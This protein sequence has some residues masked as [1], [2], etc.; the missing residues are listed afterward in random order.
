M[1]SAAAMLAQTVGVRPYELDW[2]G[3][4][5]DDHPAIVD[6]ETP[7]EWRV[8]CKDAVATFERTREQQIWGSFVGKLTYH[9]TGESPV[10]RILLQTPV[11]I[12]TTFD[13]VTCWIYGNNWG[14]APDPNTPQVSVDALF[15]DAS[16]A[17]FSLP[18]ANVSW[19]EWFLCH[20]RLNAYGI[21]RMANG[22]VFKGFVI[23]NGRNKQDRTLFFDSLAVFT[24]VFKP[25][26]FEPRPKRGIVMFPG[27]TTGTNTGPG[28][29]PFPTRDQTILP[30]NL[31][32]TAKSFLTVEKG[33]YIFHYAG[34]DGQL[35]YRLTPKTG[36]LGDVTARWTGRGGVIRPCVGGGVLLQGDGAPIAPDRAENLGVT[37]K[38]DTVV[39]RWRVHAGAITSEVSY[40][41][42]LWGKSLVVDVIAPGGNVGEVRYGRALGLS[43]PRLVTLPYYLYNNTRPAVAVSGP[44][45]APLFLSAHTD[46]CLSNAS[47]L[48]AINDIS[49]SGV[50][51]N[52]GTQYIAKTDGKRND[53]YERLFI[54]LT[55]NFEETLPNIPNPVS[56]YKKVTGTHLWYAHGA[57]NRQDDMN[58]W[59]ECKR[60][61]MEQV[62]ITDHETMWRDG[63]ESF[64]FRTKA[65][66]KKGGDE[67]ERA[68]SRYMQDVLGFV[69][70]PYNNYTDFAP[71]NEFWSADMI[72]RTPDNQLQ[73]AWMRCYAPKPARAVEYCARLAPQIQSKYGFSTAYCDVHTAVAP[74]ERVDYD[75]RVPGAGTFGAVFYSYGEIMMLQKAAWKGPVYSEGGH[76][77]MYCGLTDG[78]YGQDQNY[79][80]ATKPWLVD[81]DLRKMHDLG[82]NFGMGNPGMFFVDAADRPLDRFLAATVAF[83]HPGFLCYDYGM[84]GALRSYYMLQQ[85][86][87]R[88]TLASAT[89]IRYADAAG[90]L[91]NSTEAV[92][93]GVYTR[94]QI[95]T[96]YSDGTV[97]A[98]NGNPK[99]RM[100]VSAYGRLINLPP[101]GY[102]G[103]TADGSIDV[104]GGDIQ[105]RR[106]DYAATP[107]YIYVDGRGHFT[108][109]P[110]AACSGIGICRTLSGGGWEII[111][112]QGSECGFAI[113]ASSAVGLTKEGKEIGPAQLRVS[114]GLTYVIPISDAFSYKLTASKTSPSVVLKCDRQEVVAGETVTV[115]GKTAHTLEIPR[116]ATPGARIWREFD[117]GWIDFTVVPFAESALSLDGDKLEVALTSHLAKPTDAKV[118]LGT[119]SQTA[120]IVPNRAVT[121]SFNLGAPKAEG[122]EQLSI[123][124]TAGAFSMTIDRGLVTSLGYRSLLALPEHWTSGVRLRGKPEQ[125]EFSGTNA[126]VNQQA[127]VSGGVSRAGFFMHPPYTGGVGYSFALYDAITLPASRPAAFRAWVGKGDG[128]DAGDGITYFL[129]VVDEHGVETRI[130]TAHVIKHE[131]TPIE[132]DLSPWAGKKIR[133]KLITDVG[134]KDD[135]S[136]DWGCWGDIR[137]ESNVKVMM[138][139]LE[140]GH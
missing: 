42:C 135:S 16:G 3:R 120:N 97:T 79:R 106:V 9:A 111:P 37:R 90:H 17:E 59:A 119:Q 18:I 14:Y 15:D 35:T 51:I 76:H 104:N 53:C 140:E 10:V 115:Q 54:T 8:N 43:N 105:G 21:G 7:A 128:S 72:N 26:T 5:Q 137:I 63:G 55:P 103:W 23:N 20:R 39:S 48:L 12:N 107:A 83:G 81:F 6:F 62:V 100:V 130:S 24:E 57:G 87:S 112:F 125:A 91:Y 2:A 86:H 118:S 74:M 131:W 92:A 139:K 60:Y 136:G 77:Y 64:T 47:N 41:Y 82:C 19:T 11:K 28:K 33:V 66:P 34:K 58:L 52:G 49:T 124:V 126:I 61:G 88:Y 31:D 1:I 50:T 122:K 67:G 40:T 121:V 4:T 85:L 94:S 65:A 123:S 117:G 25:L 102:T 95:V 110:K 98:A 56:P 30:T 70:G 113:H 36:T 78:N 96:R 108:R 38:G 127:T 138:R 93:N 71:V 133:L 73:N 129:A 101:D 132:A 44:A 89:E 46:W 75:I 109:F 27:Q 114:R 84:P 134:A 68:Y 99:D 29:L 13:A 116:D 32:K 22:G 45:N 69:Y 80:I